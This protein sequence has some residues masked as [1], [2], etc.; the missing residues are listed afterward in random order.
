LVAATEKLEEYYEKSA[1]SDAHIFAM[2]IIF[3]FRPI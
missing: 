2:G 1:Q 3:F